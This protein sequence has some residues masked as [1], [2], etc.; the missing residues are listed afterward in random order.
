M[1]RCCRFAVHEFAAWLCPICG[2][3]YWDEHSTTTALWAQFRADAQRRTLCSTISGPTATGTSRS[4]IHHSATDD[5]LE[6][7][8]RS[9]QSHT[10]KGG[11]YWLSAIDPPSRWKH[12]HLHKHREDW[13]ETCEVDEAEKRAE[14]QRARTPRKRRRQN[15]RRQNTAAPSPD[16]QQ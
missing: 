14:H 11:N 6:C 13:F 1:P 7:V 12:D 15:R 5:T 8:P 9:T 16:K 4:A 3:V 10:G 2:R